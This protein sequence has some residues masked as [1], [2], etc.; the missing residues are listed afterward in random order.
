MDGFAELRVVDYGDAPVLPADPGST[1]EAI[2]STVG[3][4]LDAGAVPIVLGGDHSITEPDVRAC[5]GR[6][7]R[8]TDP[9]R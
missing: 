1:H 7:D 3:E 5:A 8:G 2:E 9:F 4:V 6:Q